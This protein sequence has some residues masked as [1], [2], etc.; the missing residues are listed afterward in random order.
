MEAAPDEPDIKKGQGSGGC[1]RA[2]KEDLEAAKPAEKQ[3]GKK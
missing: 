1:R 3:K 2:E